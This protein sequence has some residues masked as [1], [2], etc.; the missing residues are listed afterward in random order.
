MALPS[1]RDR[2]TRQ[3]ARH[4]GRHRGPPCCFPQSSLRVSGR[5]DV[6][7]ATRAASPKAIQE[8]NPAWPW[9][10]GELAILFGSSYRVP[11]NVKTLGGP[12][13]ALFFI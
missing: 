7:E 3:S 13:A 12:E 6:H 8:A 2:L 11:R 1:R 5:T 9:L 4:G 10:L